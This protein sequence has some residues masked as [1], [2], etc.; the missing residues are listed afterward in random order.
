M[1]RVIKQS[2]FITAILKN[3]NTGEK[4]LQSLQLAYPGL[5]YYNRL[6]EMDMIG[7]PVV[8]KDFMADVQ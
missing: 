8:I 6:F 1:K 3:K 2:I 5:S 7:L 4:A